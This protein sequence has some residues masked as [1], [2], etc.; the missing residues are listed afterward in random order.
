ME[1]KSRYLSEWGWSAKCHWMCGEWDKLGREDL[2]FFFFFFTE[3]ILQHPHNGSE[4]KVGLRGLT[5]TGSEPSFLLL[6]LFLVL[7]LILVFI[8]VFILVL[9]LFL[10]CPI[11]PL[12]SRNGSKNK[13]GVEAKWGWKHGGEYRIV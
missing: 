8:L 9:D 4:G 11:F 7:V 1:R 6:L 3:E 12:F 13:V 2:N 10:F 5:S